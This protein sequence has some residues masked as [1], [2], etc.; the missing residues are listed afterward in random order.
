MRIKKLQDKLKEKKIDLALIFSLG[1]TPNTNMIYFTGY[2]GIGVL[3]V[4][5]NNS[6]LLVPDMEYEKALQTKLSVYKTEKKKRLLENLSNLVEEKKQSIKKIGIEEG[7]VSV[8]VYK[9]LRKA[10]KGR[11]TDLSRLLSEV[12]MIKEAGELEKI[13][14]ACRVTDNIFS[15]ICMNFRF[16]TETG[17][18]QFIEEEIRKANCDLA[19]PPIVAS[20]KGT[21]QP[22]YI[23]SGKIKKGFLM[24][25]FGARY[26]GYCADMTRMLYVGK[27]SKKE[28]EDYELVLRTLTECEKAAETKKKFADI[29]N[30]S[31]DILGKKSKYFV[32]A[33][34]H[35]LGLDI[36]ESPALYSEDKNRIKEDIAFTVEPGIYFPGRYGIRIEDTVVLQRGKLKLL[37]ESGKSLEIIKR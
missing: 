30:L 22:H 26:D 32:H 1:E 6:F 17:L 16:S 7:D 18:K 15:K 4:L 28:L 25:D 35:G 20:G 34:G 31:L 11:Y 29:Y 23:P 21:S 33:L 8:R 9:K 5:C 27:P 37:T 10:V 12:R 36:H 2:S 19:F 14:H 13:K 24:L 3:A